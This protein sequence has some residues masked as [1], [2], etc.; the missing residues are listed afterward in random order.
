MASG[1]FGVRTTCVEVMFITLGIARAATADRS[2]STAGIGAEDWLCACGR[3]SAADSDAAR[4]RPV[5]TIPAAK[6]ETMNT[7]ESTKRLIMRPYVIPM[8][9]ATCGVAL[10]SVTVRTPSRRSAAMVS[11]RTISTK[12]KV[13]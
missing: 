6:P 2:G 8:T 3:G 10:W 11:G 13:R 7:A 1:E 9:C 12:A 4:I 5:S